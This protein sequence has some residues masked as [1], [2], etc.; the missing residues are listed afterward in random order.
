MSVASELEENPPE[1]IDLRVPLTPSMQGINSAILEV[2]DACLKELRKTNKVDVEDLTLENGLF[3]SFD[4]IVRRQLDPIWHILGRKT[5]QLVTDL[6]T[7]RKLADY[8]VRYDAV[9]FLKYLDTLRV[10][11][12]V[13]SVWIF[14][15]PTHKIFELAKRRVFRIVKSH[16]GKPVVVDKGCVANRGN[17]G[18]RK[19][20]RG[21]G[22]SAQESW[23]H[24][25]GSKRRKTDTSNFP[26]E[27]NSVETEGKPSD[28][29]GNIFEKTNQTRTDCD[30]SEAP[31]ED[32]QGVEVEVVAEEMPKWKVLREVLEEIEGE[33]QRIIS[34]GPD[35]PLSQDSLDEYAG[36]VLVACKDERTC[37]QLQDCLRKGPQK[38]MNDEWE[39]YL[40]GK[41]ELRG[42]RT[43][44]KLNQVAKGV[45]LLNGQS[46]GNIIREDDGNTLMQEEVAL[47]AA[48]AEV[49][50][51]EEA[52]VPGDDTCKRGAKSR[53]RGRG[54]SGK[55][56]SARGRQKGKADCI[57]RE[58]AIGSVSRNE[59][60]SNAMEEPLVARHTNHGEKTGLFNEEGNERVSNETESS[61]KEPQPGRLFPSVH[62]YALESEQRILE[63][64]RPS[65]IV[66]YDPDMAFVREMEVYKAE[67]LEKSL[68]VYFLF[69]DNSTEVQKFEASIR[70]E[71][72]AF[73]S[74]IR[75]KASMMIPA[76]QDGRM[77]DAV[78]SSQSP[79]I[80]SLNSVTRKA[81]GRKG[82]EKQ[83]QVVVDM[84]EFV[85][86][87]PCVL[88]QQGMKIIPIMLEVG[89]YILS[90]DI[91]VERKSVSD[92]FA[93]FAS[94][95]LYNQAETMTRYYKIPVLLIEFSQDKSFS[96]QASNE[97]GE[98]IVR[99][100]IVSKLSLL[101]LHF[102]RLRIL[103][104]RSL[105]ATADIF[106]T[107]KSNQDEPDVDKAMR[108]G[109]PTEDGIIEGDLRAE[110]YNT[111]AVELL[112]RLPGVTDANYRS[113]MDGCKSLAELACVP[114]ER[115]A[116]LMGGHRPA[117][118][119]R[120]FLDAKCPTLG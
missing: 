51:H 3:K 60:S 82:P 91:C 27:N 23:Q 94:G 117:R 5:K 28:D 84:R 8:L 68:K 108:V 14:A 71:K 103:W 7:L 44:K 95:R 99:A 115:L 61:I 54:R 76:D 43:R 10:S 67:H 13:R 89:D 88:H 20:G 72:S 18:W 104:S 110:N 2:M 37:L 120:D 70:R 65:F 48:A 86:S 85:S 34:S 78:S 93:S 73:E 66:V 38:L 98:D 22:F 26:S 109:V 113:L 36:A 64:L 47:L 21:R 52:I 107:L 112:R 25:P 30:T 53:G 96:L 74:L 6:K 87:L 35:G 39:K 81:G 24:G 11:E 62:F 116:E 46:R 79:S 17:R 49:A 119:L 56:T 12:D 106:M 32:V 75:Q 118:I 100:S 31:A 16:T 42:M 102:P 19:R 58:D 33:R 63:I 77:L 40:L 1:V 111:T 29:G 45:G 41:A 114:L 50:T 97:V 57:V 69:Y 90:P 59:C 105:H 83:M 92:L 4:E 101:V 80:H 55:T 15:N 9:T